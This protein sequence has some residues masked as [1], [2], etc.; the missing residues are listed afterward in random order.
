MI[1]PA[2][3][4]VTSISLEKE[5][6]TITE[7]IVFVGTESQGKQIVSVALYNPNGK[8]IDMLG[9][10]S[11]D[12]D[13]SFSTIPR[14]VE[15]LFSTTGTYNATGFVNQ[16]SEGMSIQLLYDGNKVSIQPSFS[17][18]LKSISSKTVT[19]GETLTFTASV[20]DSSL[21]GLDYTLAQNPPTGATI[22]SQTGVFSWTPTTAQGPASYVFDI[23]VKKGA[24]QDKESI[25]VTVTEPSTVPPPE[26][27]PVANVPDFVDPD[28]GAQYYL[29][30][31]NKESAYKE[32]FDT[33]FPDYTIEEAIELAIPG[34]FTEPEPEPVSRTPDFVDPKKGAQY[35]LD[36][37]DNEPS[38]KAWFDS[39]YP[40]YTIEEAIELAIPGTFEE[41]EPEKTVAPFVDPKQDPQYYVDRYNNEPSYKAWFDENFPDQ[42]IYEA[43]GLDE[44]KTGIC[45][46]GTQFV[47]GTCV[48]VQSG[49]GGGCL[50]AT[51]AYGSEMSEQVQFLR[52]MR[53]NTVLET[54]SG[55]AFMDAFNSVYYTFSPAIADLER[56]SPIFKNVV[57]AA[58]TPLLAS[59]SILT[60]T[61]I[62][63][64]EEMLG[65]G[66]GVILLNLGMYIFAPAVV[67]LKVR[68][69][70]IK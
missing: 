34:T 21:T 14:A 67:A 17:L 3:G 68:K 50:I 46:K 40:D 11:S 55:S 69:Y 61:D 31:Y 25:T 59:L 13:G 48:L 20:T 52:E 22:N 70:I 26:P 64:E 30:R 56:Q 2:Y 38:Y 15:K 9:D 36:R 60:L 66:I 47:D 5:V 1:N 54:K 45:G 4:E 63:S 62:D 32:W 53:D 37:Y 39:N 24:V 27:E 44:P 51:A 28:K 6:Y 19:E 35:Y 23:V 7:S 16:L 43:V 41:P 33:N 57:Q 8:F 18:I 65:F 12:A 49:G 10:L 58:I 42:T 29:D